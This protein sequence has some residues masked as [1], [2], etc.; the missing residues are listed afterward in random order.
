MS[1]M[2]KGFCFCFLLSFSVTYIFGQDIILTKDGEEMKVDIVDISSNYIKYQEFGN[3][4]GVIFRINRSLISSV[5]FDEEG[6][7]GVSPTFESP[8][9]A[10][11]KDLKSNFYLVDGKIVNGFWSLEKYMTAFEPARNN[12]TR[13]RQLK[14]SANIFGTV[15]IASLVGGILLIRNSNGGDEFGQ[16][17]LGGMAILLVMPTSGLVGVVCNSL[18]K[19]NKRKAI[20][21]YGIQYINASVLPQPKD[22]I[23]EFQLGIAAGG[24]GVQMN[25]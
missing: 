19:S 25:F 7:F 20:E 2:A 4:D 6:D 22:E 10:I 15:S 11:Y 13:A 5:N 18:H 24:I 1:K 12:F 23:I 14:N 8:E 3:A 16:A 17:I 21:K 9:I